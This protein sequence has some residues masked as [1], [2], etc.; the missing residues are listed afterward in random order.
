MWGRVGGSSAVMLLNRTSAV[1]LL[2]RTGGVVWP[3]NHLSVL[4]HKTTYAPM[5]YTALCIML[6][7]RAVSITGASRRGLGPGNLDAIS[8]GP[9]KPGP[10]LLPL[11]LIMDAA[12]IKSIMHRCNDANTQ[13]DFTLL[14]FLSHRCFLA[15]FLTRETYF[16][17]CRRANNW[18]YIHNLQ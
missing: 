3:W 17:A 12:R 13:C 18:L 16:A 6:L 5:I 15:K 7:M 8:Q 1:M 4:V 14:L 11:A 2:N 9:K 10:N